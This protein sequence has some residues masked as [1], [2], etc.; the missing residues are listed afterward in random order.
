V[1]RVTVSIPVPSG[2]GPAGKITMATK[3]GA[4]RPAATPPQALTSAP[5]MQAAG[6]TGKPRHEENP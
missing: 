1:A 6:R 5:W 3:P 4:T 2:K